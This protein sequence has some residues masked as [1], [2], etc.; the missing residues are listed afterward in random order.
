MGEVIKMFMDDDGNEVPE[1]QATRLNIVE[2]DDNGNRVRE[3][4]MV[5]DTEEEKKVE[6]PVKDFKYF[7]EHPDDKP[8]ED[9]ETFLSHY[10]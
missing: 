8:M 3:L 7:L 4:F 6:E 5:R 9:L 10:R 1:E 2:Y